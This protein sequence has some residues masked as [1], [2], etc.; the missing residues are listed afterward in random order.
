MIAN[1]L[2]QYEVP[3]QIEGEYLQGAVGELQAVNIVRVVVDDE[4]SDK[5][6]AII[7]EWESSQPA[8]TESVNI[9]KTSSKFALGIFIGLFIGVASMFW[10]YNSPVTYNGIDYTGDGVND[11]KWT[12]KDG[13]MARAEIDT[14]FDGKIDLVMEYDRKGLA[15]FAKA[16]LNFDGVYETQYSYKDGNVDLQKSDYDGDGMKDYIVHYKYGLFDKVEIG[17]GKLS[18]ARKLQSY[19]MNKLILS[20]YDSDG[21]GVYETHHEY[22]F[23]EEPK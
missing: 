16:D 19:K 9:V 12:Y 13:R 8:S 18:A 17:T 7:H 2:Q 11:E 4:L 20:D 10:A 5:A 14:N 15:E 21:D 22:D 6:K 1:L 23:Y 3:S